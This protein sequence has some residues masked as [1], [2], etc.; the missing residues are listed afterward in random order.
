MSKFV[1]VKQAPEKLEKGE[2]VLT[3]PNF[4]EEIRESHGKA[5][6]RKLTGVNHLRAIAGLIGQRYAPEDFSPYKHVVPANFDGIP[7]S[8]DEDL[9]K[10]V[11]NMFMATYPQILDKYFDTKIKQRPF[12]TKLVYFV[13]DFLHT[14]NLQRNGLD[15]IDEKEVDVYMGRKEKKVRGKPAITDEEAA[16]AKDE[17]VV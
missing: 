5:G 11:L 7:Y 2:Y 16:A 6:V 14:G 10:V 3:M 8:T 15:Q 13:G 9:S 17:I 4:L 1:V 12:G